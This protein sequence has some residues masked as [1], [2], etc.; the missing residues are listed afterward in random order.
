MSPKKRKKRQKSAKNDEN[1]KKIFFFESHS[2]FASFYPKM[3]LYTILV[4]KVVYLEGYYLNP[5]PRGLFHT[6]IPIK[7]LITLLKIIIQ[8]RF[9]SC[10]LTMHIRIYV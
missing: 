2:Y 5:I 8:L 1:E 6:P 3:I 4:Q 7:I 10:K 9:F